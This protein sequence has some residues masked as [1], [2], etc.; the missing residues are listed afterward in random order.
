MYL[1]NIKIKTTA[2]CSINARGPTQLIYFS[3]NQYSGGILQSYIEQQNA[4]LA[5]GLCK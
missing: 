2:R 3:Q 4:M 5:A 1:Q